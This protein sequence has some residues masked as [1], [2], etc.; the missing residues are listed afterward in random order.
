M[1]II[2][3]SITAT[4]LEDYEK[5]IKKVSHYAHRIHIDLSDGQFAPVKL[6]SA[7]EAWWPAMVKADFHLMDKLPA[8]A[9]S[10]VLRHRPHMVIIHAEADGNFEV[11]AR[12]CHERKVKVGVA[13]LQSTP[14]ETIIP[15]LELIDHVLIFSGDLGK[16]GGHA[17]LKLLDKIATLKQH[18]PDL[19]IG[20]DGGVNEQ[21]VA[22]LIL[23]G[24]DVLN[25]GGFIQ[26]AED[27]NEAIGRLQRIADET[28]TT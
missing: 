25:V 20:W 16:Y 28:G 3:P 7:S 2:C 12:H 4:N 23:G 18:K 17:D 1:A 19:E 22:Q 13:L 8:T 15:A 14:A 9:V 6:L 26:N 5:Q 27:A 11:F 21:N 10:T 24:V